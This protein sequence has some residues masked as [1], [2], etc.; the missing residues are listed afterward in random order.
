MLLIKELLITIAR[1]YPAIVTILVLI[2]VINDFN[3]ISA[4]FTVLLLL[5]EFINPFLKDMSRVIM[6][7]KTYPILGN[8]NRPTGAMNCGLYA[9]GKKSTSF[10]MPSGH[11]Q[12][13]VTFAAYIILTI[14][15]VFSCSNTNESNNV[16][17]T[18]PA[19]IKP[20][21]SP[22]NNCFSYIIPVKYLSKN[23]KYIVSAILIAITLAIMYSRI[24]L[25]CHTIQQVIVGG[26]I[27]ILITLI[28]K[29][30]ENKI[31]K[32]VIN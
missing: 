18:H 13:A 14:F 6:G 27:G 31:L 9:N 24:A 16:A 22:K 7:N 3:N 30:N 8:G 12:I 20:S 4:M 29:I 32:K 19:C 25:G 10:G 23:N 28:F 15:G 26:L 11:A 2:N 1:A 17:S 21:C 5:C